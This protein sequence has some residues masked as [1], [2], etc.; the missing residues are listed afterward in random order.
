V[1]P[2]QLRRDLSFP[3][4]AALYVYVVRLPKASICTVARPITSLRVVVT[5][6]SASMESGDLAIDFA[7][8]K[9]F[10]QFGHSPSGDLRA[11]KG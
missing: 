7:L 6:P 5:R 11:V 10:V 4:Q 3:K 2:R 1:L 8:R 9:R